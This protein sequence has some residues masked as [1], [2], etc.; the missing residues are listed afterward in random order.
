MMLFSY[1][2]LYLMLNFSIFFALV[3]W[4]SLTAVTMQYDMMVVLFGYVGRCR[5]PHN[6]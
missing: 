4:L 6:L 3:V 2:N 5:G 1:F